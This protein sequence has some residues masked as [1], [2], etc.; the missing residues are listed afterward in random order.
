MSPTSLKAQARHAASLLTGAA[1][2][3]AIALA[4]APLLTRIYHPVDWAHQALFL[5]IGNAAISFLV[6][7]YDVFLANL[8]DEALRAGYVRGCV[9]ILAS[10]SG[11][12]T[13]AFGCLTWWGGFGFSAL[14]LGSVPLMFFFLLFT[15]LSLIGR[16]LLLRAG[17]FKDLSRI[18]VTQNLGRGVGS[19]ALAWLPV[20][21]YGLMAGE[22]LGKC[23]GVW[24]MVRSIRQEFAKQSPIPWAFFR[25]RLDVPLYNIPGA[26]IA[27]LTTYLVAPIL[28][29]HFGAQTAGQA[30]L[31]FNTL[32]S[33]FSVICGA[34]G[35]VVQYRFAAQHRAA[36]Q[37]LARAFL[38]YLLLLSVLSVA[39]A[40]L[41]FALVDRLFEPV[42]GE[43]WGFALDVF[44]CTYP[45]VLVML[46]VSTISRVAIPLEAFRAKSGFDMLS[47]VFGVGALFFLPPMGWG[48]LDVVSAYV[49][50]QV[51][52][53]G[54]Y[55][56][57]LSWDVAQRTRAAVA[58]V[59][60]GAR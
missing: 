27:V 25:K 40:S 17:D 56:G 49:A 42:F 51:T 53:F 52:L 48:P 35:D 16:Q 57:L 28:M 21:A 59:V 9:V 13:F 39:M 5:L 4:F 14:G 55:A 31:A 8:E 15:G 58:A 32:M 23:F 60:G 3:Q 26:F 10:V 46:V 30:F 37:G 36:P 45:M 19:W 38:A 50:V 22:V 1:M 41:A 54:L 7:K 44:H 29:M 43:G 18:S 2:G 33:P 11:I 34:L 47:M 20:S 6:L 12:C 24:L